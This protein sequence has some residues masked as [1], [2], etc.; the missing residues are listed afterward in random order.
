MIKYVSQATFTSIS[1][2]P[3]QRFQLQPPALTKKVILTSHF[4]DEFGHKHCYHL[5]FYYMQLK[6]HLWSVKK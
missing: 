1:P 2:P 4:S 6:H 3:Y 5:N